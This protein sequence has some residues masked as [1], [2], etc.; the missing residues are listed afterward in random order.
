MTYKD[1]LHIHPDKYTVFVDD[2]PVFTL[3]KALLDQQNCWGKLELIKE[4][5]VTRLKIEQQ[6]T[7][8]VNPNLLVESWVSN[9]FELQK[10]WGFSEDAKF[11]RFWDI[12]ACQC[13][14]MDNNDAYPT[15]Y[16]VIAGDCPLHGS[17]ST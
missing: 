12:P 8:V 2:K 5:H 9:Q 11:H 1:P 10:A 13:P 4:L 14:T 15:G 7:E 16:Y 17:E 6:M 3:N